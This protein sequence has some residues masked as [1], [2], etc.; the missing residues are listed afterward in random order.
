MTSAPTSVPVCYRHA[1]RETYLSCT[2]CERPICPECMIPASVGHQCPECVREGRANQRKAVTAFG[3]DARVG[4]QGY[5][6]KILIAIN[7]A[8][9]LIGA[10]LEIRTVAGGSLGGLMGSSGP[11]HEWGALIPQPTRFVDQNNVTQ[12]VTNGVSGGEYYRLFTSMFIH[13][14]ILHIALNMWALWAFG[15]SLEQALGPIRFLALYLLAGLG[16]SVAVY[17][18]GDQHSLTAGASGAIFGLFAALFILLR[19][20]GRDTSSFIPIIVLNVVINVFGASYLSIAGHVGG[21]VTGA[22]V[23]VGL[24]Y[25]PAKNRTL[26]QTGVLVGVGLGLLALTMIR[27]AM[28]SVPGI[29]G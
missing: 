24:A 3:G 9:F 11:I 20:V 7:V 4:S 17:W 14:G 1:G 23:A 28:I 5:V 26:I 6:T 27:T 2:R 22:V 18:F 12:Y 10:L 29:G 15:R 13:F 16:G 19:R 21:L 25:A 8:F